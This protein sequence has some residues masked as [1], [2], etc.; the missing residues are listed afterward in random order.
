[1]LVGTATDTP[2]SAMGGTMLADAPTGP[3]TASVI[4][5]TTDVEVSATANRRFRALSDMRTPLVR[6]PLIRL[7]T[8]PLSSPSLL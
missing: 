8:T 4:P 5:P 1:V 3:T 6:L 7:G 2:G